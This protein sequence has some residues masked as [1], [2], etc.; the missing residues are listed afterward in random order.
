[1]HGE[2]ALIKSLSPVTSEI[3]NALR[4]VLT[5]SRTHGLYASRGR[6]F[7]EFVAALEVSNPEVQLPTRALWM[8]NNV[9][10]GTFGPN[11]QILVSSLKY[12]PLFLRRC[13]LKED[14]A[15]NVEKNLLEI[16]L[17]FT[18]SAIIYKTVIGKSKT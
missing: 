5:S 14:L 8:T 18:A 4:M 10:F 16:T 12:I 11:C 9:R 7:V 15:A 2:K 17:E 3:Y 13:C 6:S 1:M